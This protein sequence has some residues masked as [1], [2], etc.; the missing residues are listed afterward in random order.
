MSTQRKLIIAPEKEISPIEDKSLYERFVEAINIMTTK[1]ATPSIAISPAVI[2]L[3]L[4]MFIQTVGIV[5]WAASI[6]KEMEKNKDEIKVLKDELGIQ[7]VYSGDTREKFI[8]ME[9]LIDSIQKDRQMEILLR[10]KEG[11]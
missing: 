11:K 3:V 7:K 10:Q 4:T 8:K 9:A 5:W 1:A 6:S 2:G